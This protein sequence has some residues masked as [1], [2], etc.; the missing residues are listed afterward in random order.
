MPKEINL[1]ATDAI[2]LMLRDLQRCT[3]WA[4]IEAH[5]ELGAVLDVRLQ[6]HENGDWILHSGD[7]QYDTD[8][9]GYWGGGAIGRD[10]DQDT[11][12]ATAAELREQVAEDMAWRAE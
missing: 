2:F 11:L 12:Y 9:N 3:D 5:S 7:G 1:P 4:F 6:V 8:H 10:C